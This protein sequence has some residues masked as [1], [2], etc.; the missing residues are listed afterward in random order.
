[1]HKHLRTILSLLLAG[2]VFCLLHF[3]LHWFLWIS[4]P[5]ALISWP[6]IRLLL[7]KKKEYD[8]EEEKLRISGLS[9]EKVAEVIDEGKKQVRGIRNGAQMISNLE[10]KKK[11][12]EICDLAEKIFNNFREDPKDIKRARRF[13]NYYLD[14][15]EAVIVKYKNLSEKNMKSEE[16]KATLAKAEETLDL[17]ARTFQKQLEKL[18]EN[19]VMDLDVELDILKKTMKAEGVN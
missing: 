10:A 11:V 17:I 14:A 1:M 2:G 15:T 9:K 18:L 8:P 12:N 19:D 7:P 4:I 6:I 13:L 16:A 5:L 3:L